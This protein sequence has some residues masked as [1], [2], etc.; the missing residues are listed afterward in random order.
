ANV[1]GFWDALIALLDHMRE[2]RFIRHGMEVPYLVADRVE[3]VVPKLRRAAAE[4]DQAALD[5]SAA[6]APLSRM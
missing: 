3:D 2:A 6:A 4:R 1:L 5:Q